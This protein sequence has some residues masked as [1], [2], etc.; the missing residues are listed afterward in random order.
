MA[1][2]SLLWTAVAGQQRMREGAQQWKLSADVL[3]VVMEE[4]EMEEEDC[5]TKQ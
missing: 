2:L 5:E 3:L 1:P 4:E